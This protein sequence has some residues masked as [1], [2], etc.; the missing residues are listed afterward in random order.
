MMYATIS[1]TRRSI[2]SEVTV[3]LS[4]TT[5]PLAAASAVRSRVHRI[6]PNVPLYDIRSMEAVL[7]DAV[8]AQRFSMFLIG[9]LAVVAATLAVVGIYGVISFIVGQRTAEL[10]VRMALG[11]QGG[12]IARM[13]LFKGLSL[14]GDPLTYGGTTLLLLAVAA[15]ACY[16]PAR[17]ASRIDP[18]VVMRAE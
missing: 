12:R 17:R 13:V 8:R 18:M 4:T 9:L 6:D 14:T 7:A 1:Q 2:A 16:V 15:L 10:G 5:D 3:V 11:A